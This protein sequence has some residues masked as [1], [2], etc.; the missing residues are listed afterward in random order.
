MWNLHCSGKFDTEIQ[1]DLFTAEIESQMERVDGI[2][3]KRH[4]ISLV[5]IHNVFFIIHCFQWEMTLKPNIYK[6]T[7]NYL[8]FDQ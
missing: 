8:T 4:E 7:Y 3:E 6:S 5:E 2:L 1:K